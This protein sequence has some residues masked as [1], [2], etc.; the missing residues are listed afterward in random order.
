[1]STSGHAVVADI[2]IK[3]INLGPLGIHA[4]PS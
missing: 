1:M 2:D 4:A 3:Y